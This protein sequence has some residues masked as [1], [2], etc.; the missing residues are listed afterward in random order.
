MSRAIAHHYA[1]TILNFRN[2]IRNS[3]FS[4][5][6]EAHYSLSGTRLQGVCVCPQNFPLGGRRSLL[7]DSGLA[8]LPEN[9][10]PVHH[11]RWVT[12]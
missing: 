5:G 6:S 11:Q 12:S 7:A 8:S 10:V 4:Y 1:I 3:P 9:L 2:A